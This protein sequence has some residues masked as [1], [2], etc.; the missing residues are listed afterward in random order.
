MKRKILYNLFVN[1]IFIDAA[2]ETKKGVNVM[3]TQKMISLFSII[4]LHLQCFDNLSFSIFLNEQLTYM[5]ID[6]F[7]WVDRV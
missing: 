4:E 2:Y 6:D 1:F 5:C 3:F 7:T